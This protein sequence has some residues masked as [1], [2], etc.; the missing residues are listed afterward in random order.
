MN[1]EPIFERMVVIGVGLIGGSL[2]QACRGGVARR[3]V[4]LDTDRTHLKQAVS[5]GLVDEVGELPAGVEGADLV[6]VAVPVG[7]VAE[8]VRAIAPYLAPGCIVTDV[9]SVKGDL[10]VEV[11]KEIPPGR[12]Y[13]AGHPIAGTERSGPEAASPHLFQGSLCVLTP[14]SRTPEEA[15]KRVIRLWEAMGSQVVLM[16]PFRHDQVFALVSHL[17]HLVAYALIGTIL[18]AADGG[19]EILKFSAGGLRDFTRIAA[20]HPLMWRD[21]LIRNRGE[22]L[23]SIAR[24]REVLGQIEEMIRTEDAGRLIQEFQRAKEVR[25]ELR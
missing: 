23:G 19:E 6:V 5:L 22:V 16:D 20:S 3:V 2:A 24:F 18:N 21:I 11:E 14:T 17:P 1:R 15:L 8:L 9:G 13:V 7:A 4:G 25:E 10:V 12:V